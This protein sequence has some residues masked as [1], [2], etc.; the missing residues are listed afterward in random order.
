MPNDP[1]IENLKRKHASLDREI[2]G[3]AQR[4]N[5]DQAVISELKREKLKLKDAIVS[6][7]E[8]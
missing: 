3:E 5:P 4:P 2:G 8:A 6:L 1:R 7:E